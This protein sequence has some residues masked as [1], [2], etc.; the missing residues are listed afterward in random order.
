[1]S[2]TGFGALGYAI[3]GVFYASLSVL[4]LT[5]WRGRHVGGYLIAACV[6]SALWGVTLAVSTTNPAVPA[7]A[8]FSIEVLRGGAWLTFLVM[9]ARKIGVSRNF[10]YLA[11]AVWLGVLAAG[12]RV[13]VR[14]GL[15]WS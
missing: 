6:L 12:V 1:M 10:G 15:F 13:V 11:H 2:M 4:L 14:A 8:V 9:L 3:V 5:S 7:L